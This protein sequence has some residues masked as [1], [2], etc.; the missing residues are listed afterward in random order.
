MIFDDERY[1]EEVL[2]PARRP[3]GAL[4]DDLRVRYQVDET[5]S[6]ATVAETARRV[7]QSWRLARGQLK[8]K[9]L[10]NRLE[11]DDQ[12]KYREI[13]AAAEGGDLGPLHTAFAQTTEHAARRRADAESRLRAAA[14]PL[15]LVV[16]D[17][18]ER[19]AEDTGLGTE[20]TRRICE[21]LRIDVCEPDQLPEVAPYVRYSEVRTALDTLD[22]RHLAHFVFGV[23]CRGMRVLGGFSMPGGAPLDRDALD[24]VRRKWTA[25]PQ[26]SLTTRAET[27][28]TALRTVPDPA[29]LV[30]YDIVARLRERAHEHANDDTLLQHA[31]GHLDLALDEARRLVFAV[32]HESRYKASWSGTANRLRELIDIGDIVGAVDLARTL[33][34]AALAGEVAEL[35]AEAQTRLDTAV[36]LRNEAV[37]DGTDPDQAWLKLEDA[38]RNVPDLPEAGELQAR[39]S[40]HP[41]GR[42]VAEARD[43]GVLISWDRSPSKVGEIR[44][45]VRRNGGPLATVAEPPV[46]DDAPPVNVALHYEVVARR[47]EGAAPPVSAAPIILRPEPEEVRVTAGDG[48]VSGGWAAPAMASRVVVVRDGTPITADRTGFR[49]L[50]VVNGEDYTYVVSA[51]YLAPG[52]EVVTPGVSRTVTPVGRPEPVR[53]FELRPDPSDQGAFRARYD[54]PATGTLEIVALRGE[55]PWPVGTT[56][57]VAELR[58]ASRT[59]PS[60]PERDGLTIRPTGVS[61]VLLAV[62]LMGDLATIGGHREHVN[63]PSVTD[64]TA[65]RRGTAVNVG[66]TWPPETSEV[67]VRWS[68]QETLVSSARYRAQGGIRL[69]SPESEELTVEVTPVVLLRGEHVTGPATAVRLPALVPV[70][71][72]VAR[73]GPPWRRHLVLTLTCDRPVRLTRLSLVLR[74]GSILPMSAADGVTL[75]EWAGL[76]VPARLERPL[77]DQAGPYWLR[78]FAD[79]GVEL[80]DPPVRRLRTR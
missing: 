41:A 25:E 40:P 49:D 60:S 54:E 68:G 56:I 43:G 74:P 52:G 51:V 42:P 39:L 72:D 73:E 50:R 22:N 4:P 65:E 20:E 9:R 71:Y 57:S 48:V 16:P 78:C 38:L 63:L 26:G 55:P 3:G 11:A 2:E 34:Q 8:F 10:V 79:S 23:T 64:L 76:E 61:M 53:E 12:G 59:V 37:Q 32:R 44:Y 7:R 24:R 14:G 36:R 33:S 13:F 29:E 1:I 21:T 67:R 69:T 75:A 30:R 70:R 46:H 17:V 77:P 47:G 15:R 31:T 6:A 66:F 45:E 80:I 5:M 35:V 18:M 28:L 58:A 62:T 27:V 19:I